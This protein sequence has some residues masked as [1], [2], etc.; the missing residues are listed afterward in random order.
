MTNLTCRR[1]F[2]TLTLVTICLSARAA[3]K[4]PRLFSNGM[5]L[6]RD[7]KL[8][9]WGWANPGEKVTVRFNKNKA[10]TIT[11][12]EGKWKVIL[13]ATAAGGPFSMI[14]SG[15]NTIRID[16]VWMGDVWFCSGQSNM[17]T[18]MERVKEKYPDEIANANYPQIRNFFIPAVS[19]VDSLHPDLPSSKWL[20]ANPA[21]VM[22]FGA[23][24]YFFAKRLFGKYHVPI[25]IINS[26]VGG[27]P[28]QAWI[29]GE[30]IAS[31]PA[32]A[33]RLAALR[34]TAYRNDLA[35]RRPAAPTSPVTLQYDEPNGTVQ[36]TELAYK[37]Y[38]WK[39]FWLPGYWADQGVK[40][41]N[42]VVYFRKEITLTEKEAGQPAKLFLGRIVD[43]DEAFVNGKQVG[44]ITYQYPPRRYTVPAGLL[45]AGKNVVAVKVTNTSGKGG[46]VP[47]KNY[48]LE[49]GDEVVDLRGEWQYRVHQVFPPVGG[50]GGL[51]GG[52]TAQNEPTG[53]YNTMVAPAI[54]Y[55][56]KGFVWYQGEA[57]SGRP[58]EYSALLK[59]LIGDWRGKWRQG[60]LP[61]LVIQLPN[62]MEVQYLPSESQWAEM[63]E[64]QLK[65]LSLPN[66]G[67]AV[68]IDAGEW[69]DIHPLSKKPVGERAALLAERLAYKENLVAMGPLYRSS[70]ID[71]NKIELTFAETGGGLEAKGG[72]MLNQ[73]AIAGADK[74]FVWARATIS[75][76]KVIVWSEAVTQPKYVRY[77]W[78][79][80]P[81]GANLVNKEGLPA[82]PFRTDQ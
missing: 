82:S 79:D 77:A 63:R 59:T 23:V 19:D 78:A 64:A 41:L 71:G 26:S 17:V 58:Q 12:P 73:F 43:A 70:K 9:V 72:G 54:G 21:N 31:V 57:N 7:I 40:G 33:N 15:S 39:T 68:A 14:V 29:S 8:N 24:S 34:D 74:K 45:K 6:Q 44:N 5:V 81:E 65:A 16:D 50:S 3:V 25:G 56:L 37:P 80:N 36:W 20:P 4:L 69:N 32:Y 60:D 46:F 2:F 18:P 76:D 75:G 49:V 48:S 42:G 28:I 66:T 53:L 38:Q 1:F 47:D 61:F 52:I 22:S 35:R 30:G 51:E 27:T 62:F 13:P 11:S 67:L 10:S 55:N